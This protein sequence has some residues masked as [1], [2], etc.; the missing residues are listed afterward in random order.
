M[1]GA[2]VSGTDDV[3]QMIEDCENRQ[4]KLSE[5]EQSF[6]DSISHQL[7]KG[8]VLTEKQIETLWRIWDK[9]T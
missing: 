6:I 9:V 4:H 2:D 7:S 8:R 3:A 5:W 1:G